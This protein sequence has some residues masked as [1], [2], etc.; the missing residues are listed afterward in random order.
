[1]RTPRTCLYLCLRG[2]RLYPRRPTERVRV[3][4]RAAEKS[5]SQGAGKVVAAEQVDSVSGCVA[6]LLHLVRASFRFG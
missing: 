6:K 2:R 5:G 1:M 4:C 3:A